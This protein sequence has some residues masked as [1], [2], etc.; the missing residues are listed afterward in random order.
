M[1]HVATKEF[2]KD[3][4]WQNPIGLFLEV[5]ERKDHAAPRQTV[6]AS[7]NLDLDL[8]CLFGE[9]DEIGSGVF[10]LQSLAA[11][12][13]AVIAFLRSVS[14]TLPVGMYKRARAG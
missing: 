4:A 13:Q 8:A 9:D 7:L 6:L 2:Q 3:S 12:L 5:L 1:N 11:P 14:T 10:V